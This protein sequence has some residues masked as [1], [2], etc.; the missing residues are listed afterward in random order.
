MNLEWNNRNP[1]VANLFNPA[2]CGEVIRKTSQSYNESSAHNLPFAF[3]F[4]IL[5]ILLHKET[6]ERMPKTT[7]SYLFAWIEEN[8]DLFFDFPNRAK[9]LVPFTKEALS[10]LLIQ[11]SIQIDETGGIKVNK[12]RNKT[13][14]GSDLDEYEDIMNKTKMLGKWL[15][16]TYDVKSIY[17]FLRITP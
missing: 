8:D 15:A 9:S 17:S 3:T 12:Y 2:F 10:F 13:L 11:K 7:R 6:R 5:P 16:L 14:K 1:I 4:L